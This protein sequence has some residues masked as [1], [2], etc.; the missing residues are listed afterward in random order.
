MT[1]PGLGNPR[2][3]RLRPYSLGPLGLC[4]KRGLCSKK[5]EEQAQELLV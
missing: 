5:K 3:D 2:H 1:R 4:Y